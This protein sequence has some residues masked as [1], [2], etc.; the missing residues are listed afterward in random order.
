[1]SRRITITLAAVLTTLAL[2]GVASAQLVALRHHSTIAGDTFSGA[3]E[4]VRAQGSFLRDQADAAETWVRIAAASDD[5]QY[6]RIEH[7]YGVKQMRVDYLAR[8]ATVNRERRQIDS[9]EEQAEAAWLLQSAKRGLAPWPSALKQQQYA[10]SMST[11]ESLLRNWSVEDDSTNDAF[12]RALATEAGILRER[13]VNDRGID[14]LSRVK[15]VETLD[16][17]QLLAAI[18]RPTVSN[19]LA[20]R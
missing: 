8:K 15:A 16:R 13:I 11:I 18:P 19:Q 12:R 14:H 2:H 5:L 17:L 10:M 1:M 7:A 9:A 3:S 20:A 4:L 6:Q